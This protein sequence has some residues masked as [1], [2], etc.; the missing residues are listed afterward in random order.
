LGILTVDDVVLQ[1]IVTSPGGTHS[2]IINGEIMREGES[3]GRLTVEEIGQNV[4]KI[5]IDEDKYDV[6][7]YE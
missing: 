4:I 1:G 7:L 6:K 2:V 5:R 3:V